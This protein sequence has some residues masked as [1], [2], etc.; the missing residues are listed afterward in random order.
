MKLY[1]VGS[2]G[3]GKSTLAKQISKIANIP[4]H[5]LDEVVYMADPTDSWGNTK[6]PIEERNSLFANILASEHYIM[7]DAGREYFIEGCSKQ[8]R[9][10]YLI[11]HLLSARR[12][13]FFV[14]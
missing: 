2:V 1:I 7:E 3:S 12:E 8:I 5:H 4:C 13:Y 14:G 9:S 6:R 10:F 11:Y